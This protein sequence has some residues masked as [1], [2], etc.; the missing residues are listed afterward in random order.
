MTKSDLAKRLARQFSGITLLDARQMLDCF[1][2]A[3][4]EGLREGDTVE[5]RDFG[6][7]RVRTRGPRRARNPKTGES[8]RVG[9]KKTVFFKQG[10]T[11]KKK[12]MEKKSDG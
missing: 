4:K 2:E 7:L 1:F 3:M 12:M 8:V 9:V 11:I 10:R 6:V 5:L